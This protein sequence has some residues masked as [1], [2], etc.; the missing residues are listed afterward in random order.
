MR[1]T[2]TKPRDPAEAAVPFYFAAMGIEYAVLRGRR[3]RQETQ[4]GQYER[5]DTLT[6]LSMGTISLLTPVVLPKLL[7]P[8]RLGRS[9]TGR[10]LAAT[11]LA[12]GA[13]TTAADIWDRRNSQG[14]NDEG[15]TDEQSTARQIASVTGPG[16]LALGAVSV[17]ATVSQ[18]MTGTRLWEKRFLPDLGSGPLA[19]AAAMVSWDFI[20]YWNHRLMHEVRYL[21]AS[22]VVHHSSERYNLS[23][24]LRQPVTDSF[25]NTIPYGVACLFGIRPKL[26]STARGLNLI[27]QFWVHTE[28]IGKMGA[29]EAVLNSPSHHRVHHGSNRQY[30]DRNHGGILITWDRL[31]GTFE[32][33]VEPVTYGL[34]TNI[35]TFRPQ[36][37]ISHEFRDMLAD[38]A[39][40]TTWRERLSYVFRG[41]GWAL[42]NRRARLGNTVPDAPVLPAVAAA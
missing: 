19:L 10:A 25:S 37:V 34:T 5:R 31:F 42:E 18:A 32:P 6:S 29:P 27:Y 14:I 40:S 26:M 16:A 41:P 21:W 20:Y 35:R 3:N 2:I 23:T 4:A 22:H 9:R 15:R 24:A 38:V 1:L 7:K 36:R 39:Q 12:L 8:F 11:A 30:L 13:A 17:V 28:T 33:E